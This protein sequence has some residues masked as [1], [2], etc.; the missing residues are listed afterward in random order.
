MADIAPEP[1]PLAA[2]GRGE[3]TREA[4][5][6]AALKLFARKGFEATSTR[7]IAAEADVHHALLRYHFADKTRLWQAAVDRMFERQRAEFARAAAAAPPPASPG[8]AV[9]AALLRYVRYSAAHPEHAQLLIHEAIGRTER[10][11]WLVQQHVR[12]NVQGLLGAMK[13]E[14]EAGRF[15]IADPVLTSI[16]F[17]AASQ[18]IFVLA[19]HLHQLFGIS[20]DEP[21]EVERIGEAL[22][23]LV[24]A[25]HPISST[26]GSSTRP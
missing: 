13:R 12:P 3:E 22:L 24:R 20:V 16:I 8:D 15:R 17:S 1:D 25:D 21:A 7:A 4:I 26:H 18:M 23:T 5:L 2:A 14:T 10:M 6:D 11:T 19:P 9:S